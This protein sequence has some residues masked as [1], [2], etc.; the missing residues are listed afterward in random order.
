[1]SPTLFLA[2]ALSFAPVNDAAAPDAFRFAPAFCPYAVQFPAAVEPSQTSSADGSKIAA[3]DLVTGGTRLSVFCATTEPPAGVTTALDKPVRDSR[4]QALVN[5]L[6]ITD[7]AI[8]DAGTEFPDCSIVEGTL[9]A[10]GISYRIVS[11]LCFRASMTFI[12][13]AV[14]NPA[15][16]A[17]VA[18]AFVA[19]LKPNAPA[20]AAA[21]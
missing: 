15:E 2:T 18:G 13:E 1:M 5:E 6:G 19:S 14:F 11:R 10:G 4:V 17:T 21:P 7:Y 16:D 12:V 3:A 20:G 9:P 8:K